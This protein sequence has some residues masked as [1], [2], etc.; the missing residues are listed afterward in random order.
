VRRPILAVVA[1]AALGLTV[2]A[3]ATEGS[4]P[5]GKREPDSS[6]APTS[7][8]G[9]SDGGEQA[10][11]VELCPSSRCPLPY[12]DCNA[13]L[14][15]GCEVDLSRDPENCGACGFSC[16]H[17]A[18]GYPPECVDGRCSA[19]CQAGEICGE[20][21]AFADCDGD[22]LDGCETLLTSDPAHCGSCNNACAPGVPCVDGHCGCIGAE[23][24]CGDTC[25]DLS[26]DPMHCGGCGNACPDP[27]LTDDLLPRC[28]GGTCTLGCREECGLYDCD[29]D[30]G[31]PCVDIAWSSDHCGGCGNAC[32]DGIECNM[33]V[34]CDETTLATDPD[35]CGACGVRCWDVIWSHIWDAVGFVADDSFVAGCAA[36]SCSAEC[37]APW[38]DCNGDLNVDGTDGCET[39]AAR[40][41]HNC[42]ACGNACLPG[43]ICL[44]GACATEPCEEV[45]E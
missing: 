17:A 5:S 39:N 44:F 37:L 11:P 21:I 35:N 18:T 2:E 6:P 42:G 1:V 16:P 7:G 26:S 40:D 41:A 3:C 24:P 38:V 23:V 34:C 28:D 29:A 45:P 9:G 19:M 36:G 25:A 12:A 10:G 13:A 4:R 30:P 20:V 8:D 31:T 15:D 33:G 32:P 14:D 22:P 27:D 43:Q